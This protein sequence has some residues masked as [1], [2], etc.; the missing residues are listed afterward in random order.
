DGLMFADRTPK[1]A[2]QEVKYYYGLHK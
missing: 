2:M 1:P